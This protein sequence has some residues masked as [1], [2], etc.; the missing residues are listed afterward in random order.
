MDPV[1]I[2]GLLLL[3]V[4]RIVGFEQWEDA[5][6]SPVTLVFVE[7]LDRP[8]RVKG[9]ALEVAASIFHAPLL[10]RHFAPPSKGVIVAMK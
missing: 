5:D 2:E 8:R 4:A 3:D 10:P 6:G 1:V 9:V 7:G